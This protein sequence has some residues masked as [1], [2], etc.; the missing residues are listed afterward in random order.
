MDAV[1]WMKIKGFLRMSVRVI[2]RLVWM[3]TNQDVIVREE[4]PSGCDAKVER[5]ICR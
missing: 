2:R 3:H 4:G 5:V 1:N